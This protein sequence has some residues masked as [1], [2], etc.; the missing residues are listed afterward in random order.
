MKRLISFV[1]LLGLFF[2]FAGGLLAEDLP[3]PHI[4]G[5]T[6]LAAKPGE[7][8]CIQGQNF[9]PE[10]PPGV[11]LTELQVWF[12][13]SVGG[14]NWIDLIQVLRSG[15]SW[16]NEMICLSLPANLAAGQIYNVVIRVANTHSGVTPYYYQLGSVK[17]FRRRVP[18]VWK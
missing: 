11:S 18:V 12:I 5:I 2:S 3:R 14:V 17:T 10:L 6:P 4:T 16:E 7:R 1:V 8:I 15:G 9:L 13:N